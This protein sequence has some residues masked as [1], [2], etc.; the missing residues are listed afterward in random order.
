[1]AI[2]LDNAATTPM[3]PAII[4]G[5]ADRQARWFAN[6]ASTHPLGREAGKA[7]ERARA[8]LAA[9]LGGQPDQVVFTGGGTEALGLAML[10]L[11]G[12]SPGRVALSAV[13]HSCVREAA[14]RLVERFGWALDVIPVDAE[15]RVTAQA[16]EQVLTPAHKLVAVML[17]NNE[18]GTVN[19]VEALARL[20]RERAPRAKFVV[21][22]VQAFGKV[23]VDVGR[24]GVDA[25]A[26]TAHK[27]H[28]PKGI[29]A[30]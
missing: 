3:D 16:L 25:L 24:L 29:G 17:A 26:L 1:M 22:A 10:G 23:P 28:G 21:D 6:P 30:L 2:Y 13:E 9:Q 14:H 11:G 15:G 19:D 18:V 4:A 12:R 20:A 27:I 8:R 7:L 5:L